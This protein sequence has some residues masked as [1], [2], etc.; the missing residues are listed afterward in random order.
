MRTGWRAGTAAMMLLGSV[1]VAGAGRPM[2]PEDLARVVRVSDPRISPDGTRVAFTVGVPDLEGDAVDTDV[3][4]L[5]LDGGEPRR[6]TFG[7][8]A[9]RSPRWSPAGDALL[10]VSDRSGS[11]QLW[12]LSLAGGEARRVTSS[13]ADLSDPV[14]AT[15]EVIVCRSRLLP[16]QVATP[17]NWTREDLP[18]CHARTMETLLF[19]QWDRWLGDERNHVLLVDPD[20]GSLRDLTPGELDAPP[21]SLQSGHDVA[22]SPDGRELCYVR[23]ADPGSAMST[24]HDLWV[25]ALPDGKARRITDNPAMDRAPHYSPDGRFIAYTAMRQPG[26]ESDL[27]VI[28]LY[29]RASGEHRAL[30]DGLDRSVEEMVWHPASS[31]LFFAARDEGRRSIYRVDLQGGVQRILHEGWADHLA[32]DHDGFRLVFVRSRVHQPAE[33]WTVS[34]DGGGLRRLTSF[35]DQL[36]A[37]VELPPVEDLSFE[38]ADG[39]RVH[40]LLQLPPGFRED[41]RYPLVLVIHGGPQGMW[42]DRFMTTWF[43][44]PLVT[45][46]G[47]VGL[48]VNPRGSEGYGSSFKEQISRDYSGRV[49]GDL[50][51]GLEQVLE[52]RPTVDPERLAVVGGSFGGYAANWIIGHD[53]RFRCAV[54]HAGL[55]NLT[56]FFGAT[57]EL[58]F[59]AWDM[60]KTPW[61]EPDLYARHSPHRAAASMRTPTLVTHGE[62]D[63]RVPFAESLQLFTAL[64]VQDVPSRLVVFPEAGHVIEG[65][66]CNIRWW[67]EIHRWLATW[68]QEEEEGIQ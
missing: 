1:A 15:D 63:Y 25:R 61:D 52:T 21:V 36:V 29:D 49:M 20:D 68:L 9:D 43:T 62:K 24:N 45:A 58:W 16:E 3:W 65:L 31:G 50:M 8:G 64:Q 10:F 47:Y 22:V 14:W 54:S 2:A 44:F 40:A 18:A 46:P 23:N 33:L 26:Y 53:Q 30:T 4:L 12:R 59:P 5:E 35:N 57:E 48:F 56:S 32:V 38:G 67:R 19:R 39:D 41:R 66:Q 51:A 7:P 28:M 13:G 17:E 55:Y 27:E 11:D 60:G 6:L 34:A 37:E 42:G